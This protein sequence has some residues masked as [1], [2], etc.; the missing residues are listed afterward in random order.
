VLDIGTGT[1]IWA[2]EFADEFPGAVVIGTDLSPIQ[3]S[4]VPPNLKFYVDDFEQHPW[5]FGEEE[6]FDLIHWRSLCGSTGNWGRL[7]DQAYDSLK[8]GAFLEVHEYDAWIYSDDDGELAKAPWT[9]EWVSTLSDISIDFQ[10]PLNVGKFQKRWME[11]AGF[12]DVREKIVKVGSTLPPIG[13]A[14]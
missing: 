2:I 6:K 13:M 3:P 4:F 1:G 14:C 5:E 8:P 12:L 7:Y 9:K 10:K 11:E